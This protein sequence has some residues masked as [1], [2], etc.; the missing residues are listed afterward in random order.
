MLLHHLT[1]PGQKAPN[2][3]QN[4]LL[5]APRDFLGQTRGSGRLLDYVEGRLGMAEENVSPDARAV[6][7]HGFNRSVAV[8]PLIMQF[9]TESLLFRLADDEGVRLKCLFANAPS[10]RKVLE[11]VKTLPREFT[12]TQAEALTDPETG[13]RL[14]NKTV[15]DTLRMLLNNE[16]LGKTDSGKYQKVS[17][18][19]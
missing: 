8:A 19:V 11:R 15:S 13:D 12:Y 5:Y 1:K 7:V 17:D 6:V 2:T 9:D 14:N 18:A 4:T 10:K 16:F 3:S